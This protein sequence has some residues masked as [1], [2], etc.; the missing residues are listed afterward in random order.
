MIEE[1][2]PSGADAE[3]RQGAKTI[4]R[5]GQ[6]RLRAEK[7]RSLL[8]KKFSEAEVTRKTILD[9]LAM[10]KN[11]KDESANMTESGLISDTSI[12]CFL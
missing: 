11:V 1:D 5:S 4:N 7:Q 8:A 6:K 12:A 9:I 10:N 2:R 3:H